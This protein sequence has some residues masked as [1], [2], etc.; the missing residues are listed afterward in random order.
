MA[1]G[2]VPVISATGSVP[3]V[4]EDGVNGFLIEPGNIP[5]IVE[6]LKN[7][8]ANESEMKRLSQNA[9]STVRDRFN[10][11]DYVESLD[12]IYSQVTLHE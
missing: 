1:A 8:L 4:V 7:L 2:C 5:D 10:I 6:K 12:D 11:R 9:R 3:T